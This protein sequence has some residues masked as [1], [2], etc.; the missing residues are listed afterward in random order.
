M[1]RSARLVSTQ[2]S[3]LMSREIAPADFI[4]AC[5]RS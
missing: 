2:S 1:A 3:N 4:A 5:R